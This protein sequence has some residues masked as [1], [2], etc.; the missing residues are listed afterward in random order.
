MLAAGSAGRTP[1][2]A[3]QATYA[4]KLE[5]EH[6][7]IDWGME[8]AALERRIRAYHPWPGTFAIVREAGQEKRLKIFPPVEL[9]EAVLRPGEI[10][11]ADGQLRVGC[12]SGA[13]RLLEVQ[14]EGSRR[15]SATDYLRGRQP[16]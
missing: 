11:T 9:C 7:R 10:A 3:S 1:Q 13:L 5:R 12:G 8:A 4:P 2:D 15:M 16:S 6:G 14:P